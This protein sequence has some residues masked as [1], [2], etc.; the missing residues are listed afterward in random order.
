MTYEQVWEQFKVARRAGIINH[1]KA[2]REARL[3]LPR[4]GD[5]GFLL[6][7]FDAGTVPV[8]LDV[9]LADGTYLMYPYAFGQSM[10][11]LDPL[12][13]TKDEVA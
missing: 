1:I 7:E 10:T 9:E 4:E 2:S 13:I 8:E 6:Y 3:N 11:Q 5:W 12:R